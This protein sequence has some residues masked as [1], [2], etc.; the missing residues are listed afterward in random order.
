M[1]RKNL[2]IHSKIVFSLPIKTERKKATCIAWINWISKWHTQ[3]YKLSLLVNK[4]R[5]LKVTR[6]K[7]YAE[8]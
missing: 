7:L 5:S 6:Q 1:P 3:A 8:M 2:M 4:S